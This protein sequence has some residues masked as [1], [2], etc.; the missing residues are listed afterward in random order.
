MNEIRFTVAECSEFHQLGEYHDDI[1]TLEEAVE[2]Y[3]SIPLQRMNAMPSIGITACVGGEELQVDLL[4]G[5]IIDLD[6]LHYIDELRNNFYVRS[7]IVEL[8]NLFP[9]K[10]VRFMYL[11]S[12]AMRLAI[13]IDDFS[14]SYD[15]Y[16]FADMVEDREAEVDKLARN[17]LEGN[18]SYLIDFFDEIIREDENEDVVCTARKFKEQLQ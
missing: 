18:V 5:N 11:D 2:I 6:A 7:A 3:K 1:A 9:E 8:M 4:A 12:A 15:A 13:A 10:E 14:Y 17:I 16:Y